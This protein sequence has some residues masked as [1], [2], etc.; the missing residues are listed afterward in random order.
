MTQGTVRRIATF[1]AILF[2]ISA[3]AQAQTPM[4]KEA[5][6]ITSAWQIAQQV[7]SSK[8]MLFVV[9]LGRTQRKQA[10]RVKSFTLDKLVCSATIG[11]SRTYLPQQ[12]V[13]IILP[14]DE[15]L[16]LKLW[17]GLN[18]GVAAASWG[19]VVLAATCPPCAVGTGVAALLLFGAAGAILVGDDQPESLLYLAPGQRLTGKLSH[20][21]Y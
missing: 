13:A 11:R 20:L 3:A 7:G 1:F 5:P 8:A 16:K 14:G 12:I 21:N 10:C 9:T 18:C 15:N 17:L 19:T 2:I 6:A 4:S